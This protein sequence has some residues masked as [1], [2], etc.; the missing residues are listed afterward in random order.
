MN[1]FSLNDC[2]SFLKSETLENI[3]REETDQAKNMPQPPLQKI[4]LEDSILIDLT[5]PK[6]FSCAQIDLLTILRERKS[7]RVFSDAAITLE[8]LSFLLWSTQG[9]KK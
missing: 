9:V 4:C 5:D 3:D 8:E 6:N 7:R 1:N 2:R